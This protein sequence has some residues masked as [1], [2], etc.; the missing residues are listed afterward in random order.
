MKKAWFRLLERIQ[1]LVKEVHCKMTKWL[2]EEYS[3]ILI[4]RFETSRMVKRLERKINKK[5]AR[6][7]ATWSHYKFR[8][9]LKTKAKLYTDVKVIECGEAYTSKT[10]G[11]CGTINQKLGGSKTF[12][13]S[14]CGLKAD[15]DLHAARNILLRHLS[16]NC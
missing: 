13:C 2:C 9:M 16:L 10:C 4:P 14:C 8:E 11:R 12:Q 15:R 1:N 7:M 3:V 6:N 5:T